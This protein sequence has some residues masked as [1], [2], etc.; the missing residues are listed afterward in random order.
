MEEVVLNLKN[1]VGKKEGGHCRPVKPCVEVR[2]QEST[3]HILTIVRAPLF[4]SEILCREPVGRKVVK[5]FGSA[6]VKLG[7]AVF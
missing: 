7:W 5:A 2:R 3:G 6:N 1:S 4:W